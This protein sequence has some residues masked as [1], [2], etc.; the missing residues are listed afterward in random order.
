[1]PRANPS[2]ILKKLGRTL[3][4]RCCCCCCCCESLTPAQVKQIAML[5]N[6]VVQRQIEAIAER[7]LG[8]ARHGAG[9]NVPELLAEEGLD[10]DRARIG[11]V[12]QVVHL[13]AEGRVRRLAAGQAALG[14]D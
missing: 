4:H 9:L 12:E 10:A 3:H 11:Q 7:E 5:D 2:P 6:E 14:E 8:V 13:G 1:M